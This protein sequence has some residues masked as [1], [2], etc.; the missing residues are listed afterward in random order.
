M[1]ISNN[2]HRHVNN[3]LE[4]Q[5]SKKIMLA[6]T[7]AKQGD[8]LGFAT[9]SNP[10]FFKN[11]NNRYAFNPDIRY[12]ANEGF[13]PFESI[14]LRNMLLMLAQNNEIAKAI[15]A[16]SNEMIVTNLKSKK[17]P[18]YPIINKT[19]IDAD[20]H[21]IV[22]AMMEYINEIFFPTIW[23]LLN[24]K[25]HGLKKLISEFLTTGKLAFEIVYDNIKRPREIV[26]I[27][28]IDPSELSKFKQNG[29][30]YYVRQAVAGGK[31]VIL[32]DNQVILVEENEYDYGYISYVH[33]L[34]RPF[35]VM[36]SMQNAK[37][38]WF[39][40]K[41]QVRMHIKF[42]LGDVSRKQAEQLMIEGKDEYINDFNFNDAEGQMYFNG[43][44]GV[45]SYLEY[46][47]AETANSGSPEIEEVN[48]NGPDLTEV[49]SLQYWEKYYWKHTEI[50]FDRIDPSSSESWN[51]VDVSSI[52]KSELN[53]SKFILDNKI[54]FNEI[55][56]K[57]IIIQL[58][59]KEVEIGVDLSLIDAI[60]MEWVSFNNYDRLAEMEVIDK[61]IQLAQGLSTFGEM[62]DSEGRMIK[63][64]PIDWI[65]DNYLDYNAK[66]KQSRE[67]YFKRQQIELGFMTPDGEITTDDEDADKDVDKDTDV[68][69]D[70]LDDTLDDDMFGIMDSD[71]DNFQ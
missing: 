2:I 53:F 36:R 27:V 58:T 22:D 52:R 7:S 4:K 50:P 64:F 29:Q 47:T 62:E 38:N 25:N 24:L 31:P 30:I 17:Y 19:L 56:L 39:A 11:S 6:N 33:K 5:L 12:R 46:F 71:N 32:H 54:L 9:P 68:V 23:Q 8:K 45:Q 26:N 3:K 66:E 10:L 51:F 13:S 61:K 57:P 67:D 41:S 14:S 35:N 44:P 59:L 20:K 15:N 48:T 16:I 1:K 69:D 65:I 18:V 55:F 63:K 49:D 43:E 70:T 34:Q 42:N 28:P 40:V 37:I 60:S 21:E